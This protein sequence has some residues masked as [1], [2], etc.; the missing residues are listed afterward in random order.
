MT[1]WMRIWRTIKK[2]KVV[3]VEA[4]VEWEVEV[5]DAEVEEKAPG[6]GRGTTALIKP[7]KRPVTQT[8]LHDKTNG[9]TKGVDAVVQT[10]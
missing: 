1:T 3:E 5:V 10:C 9:S 4:E 7:I 6:S 2:T 8:S